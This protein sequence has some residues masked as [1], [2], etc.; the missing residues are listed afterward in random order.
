MV[1]AERLGKELL[2]LTDRTC[3]ALLPVVGKSL[4]EHPQEALA[5]VGIR[6]VSVRSSRVLP[7]TY[8][9]ELVDLSNASPA[10]MTS[11]GW[12]PAQCYASVGPSCWQS[13]VGTP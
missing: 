9:G 2:P 7:H 1:L 13:C 10:A 4:I 3:A 8:V 5:G 6:Q 12:T 11:S